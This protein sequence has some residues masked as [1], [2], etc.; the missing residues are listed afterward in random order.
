MKAQLLLPAA[1]LGTRLGCAGPKALVPLGGTALVARTL[2]R[3]A[4]LGLLEGAIVVV[5][6]GDRDAFTRA[7]DEAFPGARPR[8]VEGGAE[9][10]DSVANGLDALDPD[11]GVVVI[12]DAARPFVPLDAVRASIA[13]AMDCGAAT[14]AIP[15]IDTILQADADGYLEQTPERRLLWACQTPQTFRVGVIRTAYARARAEGF[16]GTDDATLVRRAGGR[17]L[18]VPGAPLN[19]KITTPDDLRLAECVVREGWA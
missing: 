14:V 17:V 5:T 1:G 10:Q 15:S 18:L 4:P 8:I 11:T 7:L 16:L 2:A 6:P 9:R 3:L 12:H 19:F 13:A